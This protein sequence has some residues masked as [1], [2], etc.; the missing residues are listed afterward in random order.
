M[1]FNE[2]G[3]S[4]TATMEDDAGVLVWRRAE[5]W[6]P[7]RDWCAHGHT[8]TRTGDTPTALPAQHGRHAELHSAETQAGVL[9]CSGVHTQC[10]ADPGQQ[11]ATVFLLTG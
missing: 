2:P 5:R 1:S 3:H 6:L 7:C 10:A 8:S 11:P 9:P 4:L